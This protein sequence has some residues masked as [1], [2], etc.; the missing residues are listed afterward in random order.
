M[1]KP[2]DANNATATTDEPSMKNLVT[3]LASQMSS[4]NNAM[5]GLTAGQEALHMALQKVVKASSESFID[6]QSK[7]SCSAHLPPTAATN[8]VKILTNGKPVPAR[9]AKA[10]TEGE[11]IDLSEFLP[12]K[13]S[14][15]LYLDAEDSKRKKTAKSIDSF[16][17]CLTAWTVYESIVVEKTPNVYQFLVSYRQF[18]QSCFRKYIWQAVNMYD[19]R[20]RLKLSMTKSFE[21][22]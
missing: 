22:H 6:G 3:M 8:E 2:V 13:D 18:I 21:F 4:L 14:Y 19:I 10:A 9:L 20:H 17:T 7:E 16:D 15:E 5:Q 12:T 11:F 1:E